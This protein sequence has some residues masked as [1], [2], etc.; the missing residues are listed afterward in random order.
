MTDENIIGQ[1][2]AG[3]VGSRILR[4]TGRRKGSYRE[5]DGGVAVIDNFIEVAFSY[6]I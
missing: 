3:T 5:L 6:L 1:W 2:L 4:D